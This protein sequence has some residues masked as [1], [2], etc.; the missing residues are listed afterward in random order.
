MELNKNY[1]ALFNLP[2]QF[3]I[4]EQKLADGFRRLQKA[5]HPDRHAGEGKQQQLLAVR[6]ASYI[7][8]AYQRLKSPLS[9]AEYLLELARIPLDKETMTIADGDFLFQQMQWRDILSEAIK[10]QCKQ[11]LDELLETVS[12]YSEMLLS[13]FTRAYDEQDFDT[14]KETI[15]KL[16]FV[17]KMMD[18]VKIALNSQKP[19]TRAK[20]KK[21]KKK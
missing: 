7:N 5:V 8:T 11:T 13:T 17:E 16:H 14:A 9:R 18:V 3:T 10:Q 19:R 15:A 1:F 6:F 2:Q 21:R 12:A 20:T 4:D